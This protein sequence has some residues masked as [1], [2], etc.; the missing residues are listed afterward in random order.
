M[1]P[2]VPVDGV[3]EKI[4]TD[5]AVVEQ[6]VSLPGGAV[7]GDPL[8]VAPRA[9]SGARGVA[10]S[11]QRRARRSPRSRRAT[12]V[13]T[14]RVHA[15]AARRLQGGASRRGDGRRPATSLRARE[16]PRRRRPARPWSLEELDHRLEREVRVV[17][18]VDRVEL[19]TLDQPHEMRDLDRRDAA[20][21]QEDAHAADEVVDVG[22]VR[23]HV[24]RRRS[25][26]RAVRRD[27]AARD[28]V[29][30]R[31]R[32]ASRRR[33]P[34]RPR[35]R[36]RQDRSRVPGHPPPRSAEADSR[37]SMPARRRGSRTRA[38][39]ARASRRH[40]SRACST[41]QSE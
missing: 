11:A 9:R 17:L 30:R 36:W 31:S 3:L 33:A 29:R 2:G 32:R 5:A 24:V 15:R 6:R 7:A 37:R 21:S 20:R 23:E 26:Q 27:R 28:S 14:A 18:V 12:V 34:L 19:D 38:R 35:R 40:T 8:P 41:Q 4:G 39:G 25:G 10:T 13:A 22:N 16:A 1:L